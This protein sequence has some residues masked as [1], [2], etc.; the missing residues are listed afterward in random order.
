[1]DPTQLLMS[2]LSG[3]P[4]KATEERIRDRVS[5]NKCVCCNVGDIWRDGNCR[6]CDYEVTEALKRMPR[7]KQVKYLNSLYQDGLR[8]IPYA[9]RNYRKPMSI[10]KRR[11]K[12][13]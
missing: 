9:I 6:A 10:L 4:S 13:A 5:R 8:L 3:K 1:M 11:A 12:T 7:A 2:I